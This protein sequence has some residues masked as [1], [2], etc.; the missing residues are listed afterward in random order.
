M[1]TPSYPRIRWLGKEYPLEELFDELESAATHLAPG[2]P[3]RPRSS[4]QTATRARLEHDVRIMLADFGLRHYEI[5]WPARGSP[6]SESS[7]GSLY[8]ELHPSFRRSPWLA[9]G[10]LPG[11]ADLSTGSSSR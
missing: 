7:E 4:W 8:R 3:Y 2:Y 9:T 11:R 5:V 10:A 1:S 6:H